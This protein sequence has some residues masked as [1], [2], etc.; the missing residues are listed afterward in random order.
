MGFPDDVT[1]FPGDCPEIYSGAPVLEIYP[2]D[3]RT[4]LNIH[5][6][7]KGVGAQMAI[8]RPLHQDTFP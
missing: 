2:D 3:V 7:I 6:T 4:V 8:I 1:V 5:F